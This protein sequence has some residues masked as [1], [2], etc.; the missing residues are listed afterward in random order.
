MR[1]ITAK[2]SLKEAQEAMKDR[3]GLKR[4]MV[5]YQG[6]T[7]GTSKGHKFQTYFVQGQ[8][9]KLVK[10]G[11]SVDP[12]R[13]FSDLQVGS[14]DKLVLLG[15]IKGDKEAELQ[16]YFTCFRVHGEWYDPEILEYLPEKGVIFGT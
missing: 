12:L 16:K 14:P 11:K 6:R 3:W 2:T 1:A 7:P 4:Y 13:R 10:I 8:L 9:T 15:V 5:F